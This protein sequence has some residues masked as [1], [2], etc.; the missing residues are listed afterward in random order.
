MHHA[1]CLPAWQ[2]WMELL[3]ASAAI[4]SVSLAGIQLLSNVVLLATSEEGGRAEG[5]RGCK[6]CNVLRSGAIVS[7]LSTRSCPPSHLPL[8]PL[9]WPCPNQP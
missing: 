3:G 5:S 8:V 6:S 7:S 9:R 1:V 2:G 4:G